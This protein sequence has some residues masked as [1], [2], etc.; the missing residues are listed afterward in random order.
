MP[1]GDA[2][3]VV[4]L[5]GEEDDLQEKA[6]FQSRTMQ[7]DED[8]EVVGTGTPKPPSVPSFPKEELVAKKEP[9]RNPDEAR[10][11]D[12]PAVLP[13]SKSAP[14]EASETPKTSQRRSKSPPRMKAPMTH[15]LPPK[16]IVTPIPPSR[17][18]SSFIQ[19]SAMSDI[20]RDSEKDR[21]GGRKRANG[22]KQSNTD[23]LP[24]DWEVRRSS[25]GATYYYNTRTFVSQWERPVADGKAP[26]SKP[27][28]I[29]E[30]NLEPRAASKVDE[31]RGTDDLHSDKFRESRRREEKPLNQFL[32]YDDRHYRP[33]DDPEALPS[34]PRHRDHR[35]QSPVSLQA[36]NSSRDEASKDTLPQNGKERTEKDISRP[37]APRAESD[38]GRSRRPPSPQ[39]PDTSSARRSDQREGAA[40]R[41]VRES[42]RD[43]EAYQEPRRNEARVEGERTQQT[44][45]GSDRPGSAPYATASRP[46]DDDKPSSQRSTFPH[47][48][49]IPLSGLY[50]RM[51]WYSPSGG[52]ARDSFATALK[53]IT[54]HTFG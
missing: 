30:E 9:P 39:V 4:S 28:S 17:T 21:D 50:D 34:R 22:A 1:T 10:V 44:R 18:P 19:A 24:P 31:T 45:T 43:R 11:P 37:S 35:A 20:R 40:G 12:A 33:S 29:D 42:E 54:V 36:Q 16:P 8:D 49:S 51:L 14:I 23:A 25:S 6:A 46:R 2:D 32:S 13:P 47:R 41:N 27:R 52:R 53:S 48:I 3:D 5:G 7:N 26:S 38:L 15:A